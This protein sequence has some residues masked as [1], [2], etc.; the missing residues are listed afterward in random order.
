[1]TY[2][3]VIGL[4]M[5]AIA[6]PIAG[7]P[8]AVDPPARSAAASPRRTGSRTSATRLGTAVK[9][10]LVEVLG[11]RKL[12]KWTVPGTAHFFVFWA[13]LVLATVYLEAYGALFDENFHIPVVGH[14]GVLGF[15]QDFVAV[16]AF[17]GIVVF[18]SS[19]CGTPRQRW[20]A[21]PGS[22]APTSAARG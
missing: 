5:N 17:V 14:W 12:L 19:G 16:M 15:A 13:F 1:M 7:P 21:G 10:E 4:I 11:Q 18:S 3:L 22:R 20:A 9:T 8:G 6:L 2:V